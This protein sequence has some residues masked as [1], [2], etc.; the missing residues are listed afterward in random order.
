MSVLVCNTISIAQD[1]CGAN[2]IYLRYRRSEGQ[3]FFTSFCLVNKAK[4]T[5]WFNTKQGLGYSTVIK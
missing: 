3:K 2:K 4:N 5:T 1:A